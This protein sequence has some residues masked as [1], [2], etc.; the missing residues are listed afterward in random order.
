MREARISPYLSSGGNHLSSGK[1]RRDRPRRD[2]I[3]S[4][5]RRS[6]L[7]LWRD[8]RKFSEISFENLRP[9]FPLNNFPHKSLKFGVVYT[10]TVHILFYCLLFDCKLLLYKK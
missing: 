7:R 4:K 8:L 6:R 2:R 10:F 9:K 5:L 1:S 3:S